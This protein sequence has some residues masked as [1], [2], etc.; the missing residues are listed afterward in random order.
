MERGTAILWGVVFFF[1]F[2]GS[3]L[4]RYMDS[5]G[6]EDATGQA[7]AMGCFALGVVALT[8]AVYRS[9][10][11][12]AAARRRARRALESETPPK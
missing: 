3:Q 10:L 2:A 11:E 12:P 7:I 8:Y 5:R 4:Q 1:F 9:W 6:M